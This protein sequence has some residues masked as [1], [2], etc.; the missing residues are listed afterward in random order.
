ML[1]NQE[2]EMKLNDIKIYQ[3]FNKKIKYHKKSLNN[4]CKTSIKKIIK[5]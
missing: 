2:K 3:M 5:V 1:L 4:L